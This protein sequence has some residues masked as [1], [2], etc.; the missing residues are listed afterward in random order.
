MKALVFGVDPEPWTPPAGAG[1]NPLLSNLSVTPMRLMDVP[2][3]RP[4]RPDW[5]VIRPR[6]VGICGSDSK[7]A[8][9]DFGEEGPDSA[10]IGL[11]SFPQVMGHEVVAEVAELGP[12]ASG[13]SVGDRVVLNP[14]L[15]CVPR[16]ISPICPSC[17]AGDYSLCYSF[18]S[19]SISVG[20]HSGLSSDATGGY[21][22][23]MPAHPMMLH[24]VPASLTDEAAILA[25]PF[26]VALHS[27]TRH[28]PVEGG[29]ALV[30][31][32]GS[33]GTMTVAILRALFPSVELAVVARFDAQAK[34]ASSLGASVILPPDDRLAIIEQLAEWS[35]GQIVG[36]TEGL[37]MCH[38]GGIDIVYDTIGKPETLE[39][40]VRVL[41]ARA[42]L[43]KTGFHGSGRWEWSPLYFKEISWVGSN[44]FGFE[45]VEGERKHGID[46]YLS[47]ADSGRVDVL[48]M[49]THTFRLEEWREAFATI[50]A[51]G[52]TGAIKVA[53]DQR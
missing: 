33:L 2:D 15:S 21:A 17:Q 11:C 52:E 22:E 6:L 32:A 7:M 38:P 9:L 12:E 36:G 47:L 16:G 23:L 51:Q 39:V 20:M 45:E 31:G 43:V 14:W 37:P 4:L 53:I 8:L 30:Y 24:P 48:R 49:L 41:R 27:V 1:D 26:A 10:M 50:A 3:A 19:G 25:D 35:G 18:R 13:V 46:H 5:V 44:A 29:K 34:L 28:P 42:T 40:G